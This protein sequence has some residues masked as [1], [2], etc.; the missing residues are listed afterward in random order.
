MFYSQ[1]CHA[2]ISISYCAIV[3]FVTTG[4]ECL[5]YTEVTKPS[6]CVW[7]W[8][9]VSSKAFEGYITKPRDTQWNL[10]SRTAALFARPERLIPSV[11]FS[12]SGTEQLEFQDDCVKKKNQE[13]NN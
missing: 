2:L 11:H 3:L 5:L 4:T 13:K 6:V 7:L 1:R 10:H 8:T 9:C 12:D